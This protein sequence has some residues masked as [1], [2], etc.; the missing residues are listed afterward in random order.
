MLN[1]YCFSPL[2]SSEV[3]S[4]KSFPTAFSPPIW[5]KWHISQKTWNAVIISHQIIPKVFFSKAFLYVREQECC[6]Q[7]KILGCNWLCLCQE[8]SGQEIMDSETARIEDRALQEVAAHAA[9]ARWGCRGPQIGRTHH[10]RYL[11]INGNANWEAGKPCH[12]LESVP[13]HLQLQLLQRRK[14]CWLCMC[15]FICIIFFLGR[16]NSRGKGEG[17]KI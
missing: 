11:L 9:Q 6:R 15:C 13:K 2:C 10:S 14:Q 8:Y 17:W 3:L 7:R 1:K 4:W 5:W 12:S 16:H